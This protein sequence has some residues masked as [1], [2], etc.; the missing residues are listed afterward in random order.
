MLSRQGT[1]FAG[2]RIVCVITGN[3][4]KDTEIVLKNPPSIIEVPADLEAIEKSLGWK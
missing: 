1:S 3:G 4:L 2:K